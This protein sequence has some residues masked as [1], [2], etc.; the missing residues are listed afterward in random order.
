VFTLF[1]SSQIKSEDSIPQ[2][3]DLSSTKYFPPI[4]DQGYIGSC[5]WFAVVYYQMTYLFNRAYDRSADSGTTF[6]PKFG[7]NVLNNGG[8]YPYN[9]RVDDVYKFSLKHGSATM[10]DFPYDM[11]YKPWCTDAEIWKKALNYRLETFSHFTCNNSDR[12]A[13]YSLPDST[14]WLR[15]IKKLLSGGEVLVIQSTTFSG[16]RFKAIGDD[17]AINEDDKYVGEQIIYSGNNGPDHTL[18]LVGYNDF[19]WVD[20][21]GDG[22]VQ[23]DEKGALKI[24]DSFGTNSYSHN[25]GFLW[26][27]YSTAPSSIWQCRVNRMTV[28]SSYKP[29]IFCKLTLNSARRDNIRFQFGRSASNSGTDIPVDSMFVFDPNGLGYG[30][31]TNGVSLIAGANCSFN[32]GLD[33]SDGNFVFDLTDIYNENDADYWYLKIDNKSDTPCIIKKFEI[34]DSENTVLTQDINLPDTVINKETYR[35]LKPLNS[36]ATV[37]SRNGKITLNSIKTYPNP[38]SSELTLSNCLSLAGGTV[39]LFSQ[40]GRLLSTSN[41]LSKDIIRIQM[42]NAPP[43]SYM[44]ALIDKNGR[45]KQNVKIIKM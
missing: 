22:I 23:S 28:R 36:P 11:N 42:N 6:S 14:A 3:I 5:D 18:A 8:V 44:V 16:S 43:G 15:E 45:I 29:K 19:I 26:M 9:I 21:N 40:H 10:A 33:A 4:F 20:L 17:P 25:K 37:P 2:H 39:K 31:G 7:Y 27:A 35:F 38:V 41:I 13:D 32:G 1:F 30:P 12:T 34:T 24:A